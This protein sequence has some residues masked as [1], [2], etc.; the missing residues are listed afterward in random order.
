MA[1][2]GER[3]AADGTVAIRRRGAG[4][5]QDVIPRAEFVARVTEE[6]A[7]RSVG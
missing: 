1:V 7:S 4:K 5:K 2:V 3:E 6:I